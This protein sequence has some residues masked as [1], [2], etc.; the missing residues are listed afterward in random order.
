MNTNQNELQSSENQNNNLKRNNTYSHSNTNQSMHNQSMISTKID[1]TDI[2][3]TEENLKNYTLSKQFLKLDLDKIRE[4][5]EI[6]ERRYYF[7]KNCQ[8]ENN[9][10]EANRKRKND[11]RSKYYL[12]K[13]KRISQRKNERRIR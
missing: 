5:I 9:S 13:S 2:E 3:A 7:S 6:L 8:T 1:L 10:F 4:L 11:E 12:F